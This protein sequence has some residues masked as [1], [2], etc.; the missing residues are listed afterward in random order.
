[1]AR[2]SPAEKIFSE[3]VDRL[4]SGL[5]VRNLPEADQDLKSALDFA[6][7]MKGRRPQPAPRFKSELKARL[8]QKL[9]Q[10]ET[11]VEPT[12]FERLMPR[13]LLWRAVTILAVLLVAGG[14][15]VGILL[16]NNGSAP[17]V[18]AP[19][20]T[21]PASTATPGAT[22]T[23][24][25]AAVTTAR[26]TT[27]T[28]TTSAAPTTAA[29]IPQGSITA[30]A[31]TDKSSY[32]PGEKV[33]IQVSLKNASTQPLLLSEYPPILSLMSALGNPVFTFLGSQPGRTLAAGETVSFSETWYQTDTK[34]QAVAVGRYYLEL[35]DIDL[36][37]QTYK[38]QLSQPISFEIT[39]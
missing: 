14:I 20:K 15:F 27:V 30:V 22:T 32:A 6:R 4:M 33:V 17:I 1:M 7:L 38:L 36:Q 19:T 2:G 9:A 39:P 11:E 21:V 28:A 35:E 37:G 31:N 23:T 8:L 5:E 26:P 29:A 18:Q 10:Q 25:A 24:A 16:R 34:G 13:Q 12:W 3:N